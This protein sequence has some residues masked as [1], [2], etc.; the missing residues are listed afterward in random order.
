MQHNLFD[1]LKEYI[2]CN[3]CKHNRLNYTPKYDRRF[4]RFVDTCSEFNV[5]KIEIYSAFNT[6]I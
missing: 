4:D 5:N 1:A 2:N 3:L 6:P